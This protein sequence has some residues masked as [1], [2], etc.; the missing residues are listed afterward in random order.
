[1]RPIGK[2]DSEGLGAGKPPA[3]LTG[4]LLFLESERSLADSLEC[5]NDRK[6]RTMSD[7]SD[8]GLESRGQRELWG[9]TPPSGATSKGACSIPFPRF[10]K[11]P[12]KLLY[13]RPPFSFSFIAKCFEGSGVDYRA[14]PI[15]LS[16]S[17]PVTDSVR[18][19]LHNGALG[20]VGRAADF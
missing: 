18:S 12:R 16:E 11:E 8:T 19:R 4:C 9:S 20:P 15:F 6:C 14:S 1:M 7:G 5:V 2:N 13:P 3:M 17:S 10:P